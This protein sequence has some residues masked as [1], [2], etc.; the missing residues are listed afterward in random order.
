MNCQLLNFEDISKLI[1]ATDPIHQA[2]TVCKYIGHKVIVQNKTI[3]EVKENVIYEPLS[4]NIDEDILVK[5]STYISSSYAFLSK[6]EQ[7]ALF[8][9][10]IPKSALAQMSENER[11]E[12][13]SKLKNKI[14][15]IFLN[16]SI[17]KYI[18]Q[19]KKNL[20]KNDMEFDRYKGQ[21]HYK[22]G[23]MC[24]K[25]LTF[26]KRTLGQDYITHYINRDYTPSTESQRTE[27]ISHIKKIYVDDGDRNIILNIIGRTFAGLSAKSAKN[28]FLLG[29]GSSGKSTC[30]N[31][32]KLAFECYYKELKEDTFIK[33]NPKRDK[34]FNTYRKDKHI[35]MTVIN[36]MID[37]N[38]DSS[39]FKK[40]IEG[41]IETTVLYEDESKDV[42]H[43]SGLF[44]TSNTMPKLDMADSGTKRR[45]EAYYHKSLFIIDDDKK[46][47]IDEKKCIFLGNK[48][49][50]DEIVEKGLLDAWA[51]IIF[52]RCNLLLNNKTEI[53]YNNNFKIDKQLVEESDNPH[54]DFI[55]QELITDE[56][57]LGHLISKDDMLFAYKE[58]IKKPNASLLNKT[59]IDKFR[60]I[61]KDL[62]ITLMYDPSGRRCKSKLTD[63]EATK[64]CWVNCRFKTDKEKANESTKEEYAFS[65]ITTDL[66]RQIEE[67]KKLLQEKDVE[68]AEL[69]SQNRVEFFDTIDIED[70]FEVVEDEEEVVEEVVIQEQPEPFCEFGE[71]Y[72][73]DEY[74]DGENDEC[75]RD[76]LLKIEENSI[77]PHSEYEIYKEQEKLKKLDTTRDYDSND[78]NAFLSAF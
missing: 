23:Y 64:G 36:E 12:A 69:K 26:K 74:V 45:V 71:I 17:K 72:S 2:L 19:I 50:K 66:K 70:G 25:T 62:Q 9:I 63:A 48:N 28:T 44:F 16:S 4:G 8:Y 29:V 18:P 57:A 3:Y 56:S 52:E 40:F 37:D 65:D 59:L 1:L 35:L 46:D 58:F 75:L 27:I 15:G 5:V 51:D 7:E 21:I 30:M 6:K 24:L 76:L 67:L 34:I 53:I 43:Q 31:F 68:I 73:A 20:T 38:I 49:L 32:C 39:S 60:C 13:R 61:A 77:I 41:E 22:N 33:N 47:L 54:K 10:I 14:N 11:N 42:Q 78:L 55:Q